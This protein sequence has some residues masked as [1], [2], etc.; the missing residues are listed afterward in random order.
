MAAIV[1]FIVFFLTPA[2]AGAQAAPPAPPIVIG[3]LFAQSGPAAAV[4][5]SDQ[6]VAELA[7]RQINSQGGVLGRP[8]KLVAYDTQSSPEIALRQA[9]QLV[10]GDHALAIIG[11][12]STEAGLAVKTYTEDKH[13]PVIMTMAGDA[14]I[15][16]GKSGSFAWT[17]KT[18]QRTALAVGKICDYLKGK[19]INKIG[20]M[21]STDAFG[22]DGLAALRECAGKNGID[23]VAAE[24][25]DPQGT[26][27][28]A[29]AGK[30]QTAGAQAAVVWSIG[31]A[32]GRIAKNFA[33]L[34]GGRPLLVQCHGQAG[35]GYLERAGEAAGGTVMPGTRLMAP[36]SLPDKAPQKRVIEAF[37]K[38]YEQDGD[39][40]NVPLNMHAGYV[41]DALML[42]RAAL[43]KAGKADA[44]AVRD[45]LENLQGVVGVSGVYNLS[46]QDHNGLASDSLIML[47][48]D[49]GR[50]KLAP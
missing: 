36:E 9:R 1:F 22:Q 13:V 25:F 20:I 35:P 47:I 31:P 48:V 15:A 23:I 6:L 17:F 37:L 49:S 42:L 50:Y 40:K 19:N 30:L 11:P 5:T 44:A 21:Y 39:R 18:P 29:Q 8:L 24:A 7:V 2:F 41:Y 46:S 3:G 14:V 32:G 10:E 26:D 28:S 4:G 16:G 38:A 12:S 34:S 33:A 27:F 45:A 43:E